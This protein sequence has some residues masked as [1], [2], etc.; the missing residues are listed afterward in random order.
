M[1]RFRIS[2][3]PS[4]D[5]YLKLVDTGTGLSSLSLYQW[6]IQTQSAIQTPSTQGYL[7]ITWGALLEKPIG[8]FS[9]VYYDDLGNEIIIDLRAQEEE[10]WV[11]MSENGVEILAQSVAP[12]TPGPH[13]Y[14]IVLNDTLGSVYIDSTPIFDFTV[15]TPTQ[16]A[17][18]TVVSSWIDPE[19][20]SILLYNFSLYLQNPDNNQV[21]QAV[22]HNFLGGVKGWLYPAGSWDTPTSFLNR[23][24]SNLLGTNTSTTTSFYSNNICFNTFDVYS[25]FNYTLGVEDR[26]DLFMNWWEMGRP[27]CTRTC[28]QVWNHLYGKVNSTIILAS[29]G[30]VSPLH[31]WVSLLQNG[32]LFVVDYDSNIHWNYVVALTR[33]STNTFVSNNQDFL[34]ADIALNIV[35]YPAY[36]H[37]VTK[38]GGGSD[39]VPL[40]TAT[41]NV[42]GRAVDGVPVIS[43]VPRSN[44]TTGIL[45]DSYYNTQYTGN[46][47]LV[48]A[49]TIMVNTSDL[50][51]QYDYLITIPYTLAMLEGSNDLV[52]IYVY[53]E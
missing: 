20:T 17:S 44:F 32:T 14:S 49:T 24:E 3:S 4:A 38:W 5:G 11:Y 8:A 21:Y 2:K 23:V 18:A 27:G 52:S 41:F 50:F 46:E 30:D 15:S 1:I 22:Y 16:L 43:S 51:G 9:F 28:S 34:E 10:W 6:M 48:F 29:Q 36:E 25:T 12:F 26:C 13:L 7:N 31:E 40:S 39:S 53:I 45:W 35:S 37:I 33:D 47:P 19:T 42:F